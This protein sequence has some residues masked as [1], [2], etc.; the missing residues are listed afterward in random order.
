MTTKTNWK[1]MLL[2]ILFV[3]CKS[4]MLIS[5]VKVPYAKVCGSNSKYEC[6]ATG[7]GSSTP[8]YRVFAKERP[9]GNGKSDGWNVFHLGRAA[10]LNAFNN[11]ERAL[12]LNK[13]D[14]SIDTVK[15]NY[16]LKSENV[17]KISAELK[18]E[19]KQENISAD[20][21]AQIKNDFEK[22]LNNNLIIE[23]YLITYTLNQNLTD[24]LRDA[25]NGTN[26]EQRFVKAVAIIKQNKMPLIREV[27]VITEVGK[28]NEN[29]S[30]SNILKPILEAKL[31]A[32]N[33]K[34]NLIINGT[35]SRERTSVFSSSY[36]ITSIYSYG[37]H[38][39][40]WMMQ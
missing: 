15:V 6:R 10:D 30:I 16:D 19:L 32:N 29:K 17:T 20:L 12:E 5:E 18:A 35:I 7:F 13:S 9:S 24:N 22:Q 28:F 4:G 14:Y 36:K 3:G 34:I 37:Y 11:T 23:A 27:K 2:A 25:A 31:G 21:A 33:P 40:K 26:S 38:N 39:D 1:I 8:T